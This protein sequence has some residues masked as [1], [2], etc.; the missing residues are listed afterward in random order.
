MRKIDFEMCK[1][2][3]KCSDCKETLS[4]WKEKFSPAYGNPFLSELKKDTKRDLQ[5]QIDDLLIKAQKLQLELDTQKD[6]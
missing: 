4:N 6:Q 3:C 1:P 5:Q 2:Y